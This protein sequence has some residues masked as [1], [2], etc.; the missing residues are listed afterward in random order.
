MWHQQC[1]EGMR[2]AITWQSLSL[3]RKQTAVRIDLPISYTGWRCPGKPED[4][5]DSGAGTLVIV[6]RKQPVFVKQVWRKN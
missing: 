5:F 1:G 3:S 2:Q 4:G 6:Q